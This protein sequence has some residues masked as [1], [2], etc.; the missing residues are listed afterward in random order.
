MDLDQFYKVYVSRMHSL[1]NLLFF[2]ISQNSL[3]HLYFNLFIYAFI[4]IFDYC[5]R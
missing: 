3:I 1:S 5:L 2:H 4:I